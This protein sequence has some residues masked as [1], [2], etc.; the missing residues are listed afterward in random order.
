MGDEC[1]G[2]SA[3]KSVASF[4]TVPE[5]AAPNAAATRGPLATFTHLLSGRVA[6]HR[7]SER[8]IMIS[9]V[10]AITLTI[11]RVSQAYGLKAAYRMMINDEIT[12]A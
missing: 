12:A 11:Q 10:L 2:S 8:G 6:S 7:C 5:A 9:S 1:S 3:N 4:R